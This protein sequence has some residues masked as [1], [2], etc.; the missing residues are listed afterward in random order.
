MGNPIKNRLEALRERMAYH[1]LEAYLVN[2]SDPH[3]SEYIPSHWDSRRFISGFSGSYGWMAI[4][5]QEAV[6]WTDSRYYLQA[7]MEL[8]GSGIDM[9][10]ARLPDTI[11]LEVWIAARLK[12]GQTVGF[13]SRCHP[14]AEVDRFAR[15]FSSEG[16]L[17][18]GN[19]DLIGEI[20][21]DRPEIPRSRVFDHPLEYSGASRLEKKEAMIAAIERMNADFQVICALDDLAWSFNIRGNDVEYNPVALGFGIVG[22]D[23]YLLFANHDRLDQCFLEELEAEGIEIKNYDEV[24]PYL[25]SLSGHN[26]LID[27]QRT[28]QAIKEALEGRNKIIEGVSVPCTQKAIKNQT[29]IEGFRKSMVN[30]ALALL[31]FQLWIE[32]N[33]GQIRVTEYDVA[34]KLIEVRQK[35]PGYMGPGFDPI[36]G[37]REHGAMVH[38]HVNPENALSLEPDGVLLFDSGG[39]Y[40]TGTTD[41]TRT[42][43]LGKVTEG[44]KRDYTLVLKG[45]IALSDIRFPY[46]TIGCHL[47]VLARQALWKNGL[48]YGHGTSHGVGSFL[49]VHEGPFSIRADLNPHLIEPGM[50]MS[51]EPGLYREGEYGVRVENMICCV[52]GES[53][54]FGRFLQFETLTLYPFENRLIDNSLLDRNEISWINSY[55]QEIW[56]KISPHANKSQNMLLKRLIAAI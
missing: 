24:Y 52:P 9:L 25:N 44:M 11:P 33:I 21:L 4:T 48:N 56:R 37:Y 26:I 2:G 29:E 47:D 30:D 16:I 22:R 53:N 55:H 46:G 28:N 1:G 14:V 8:D 35:Y 40:Q 17:M 10:K 13:D 15:L 3:I 45:M 7:E 19:L 54:E 43:A 36:V 32:E 51:N 5:L 12:P 34:Q 31:D 49:N 42:L 50:V 27:P 39:Q 18:N 38:L 20:W 6:L 23:L 41:I